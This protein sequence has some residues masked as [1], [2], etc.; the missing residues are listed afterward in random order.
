MHVCA[1]SRFREKIEILWD[2]NYDD[3]FRHHTEYFYQKLGLQTH[4]QKSVF[5]LNVTALNPIN[6]SLLD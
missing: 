4:Q 2:C 1:F 5:S 3:S 6:F